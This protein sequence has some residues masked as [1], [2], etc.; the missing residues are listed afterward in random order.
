[1]LVL[2]NVFIS[3]SGIVNSPAGLRILGLSK[4]EKDK[5]MDTDNGM[6]ISRRKGVGEMRDKW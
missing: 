4:L 1:M 3:H 5:L 6:V 2:R